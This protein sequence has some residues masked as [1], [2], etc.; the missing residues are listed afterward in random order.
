MCLIADPLFS[1]WYSLCVDCCFRSVS[2]YLIPSSYVCSDIVAN[3]VKNTSV[4][5]RTDNV[6]GLSVNF[7][8]EETNNQSKI[9]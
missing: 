5:N 6:T 8:I 9:F 1:V 2:D 3:V 4:C 7:G